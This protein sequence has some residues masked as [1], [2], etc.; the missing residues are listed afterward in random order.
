MASFEFDS[1]PFTFYQFAFSQ[2]DTA[3]SDYGVAHINGEKHPK[4]ED[5]YGITW[6]ALGAIVSDQPMCDYQME[7]VQRAVGRAFKSLAPVGVKLYVEVA[8]N[9]YGS[10][11]LSVGIKER[12]G[13]EI[14]RVLNSIAE[15]MMERVHEELCDFHTACY[16][17][18]VFHELI[19]SGD[20][21]PEEFADVIENAMT[22]TGYTFDVDDLEDYPEYQAAVGALLVARKL[23]A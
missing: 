1:S 12:K 6:V 20:Y 10:T 15:D 7:I 3:N 2:Y 23:A 16:D 4:K 21:T 13:V 11:L 8:Y 22:V 18:N 19:E 14:E 9:N 5:D 17:L